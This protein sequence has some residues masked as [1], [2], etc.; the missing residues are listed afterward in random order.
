MSPWL[1]L[2]LA[3][4][5]GALNGRADVSS[6]KQNAITWSSLPEAL[7]RAAQ[8]GLPIVLYIHASW[9]G[10]CRRM[11]QDVFPRSTPLLARFARA[12][13]DFDEHDARLEIGGVRQSPAAWA[14]HFGADATPAFVLLAPDGAVIA[15]ATGFLDTDHFHLLLAYVATG[16]YRHASFETY[17][18]V[19]SQP[20]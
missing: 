9:C 12:K 15:R 2:F 7:D 20:P 13:L 14:R 19:A 17:V 5:F 4:S 8:T 11:E 3:V 10:P 16:A 6:I 18:S 1:P